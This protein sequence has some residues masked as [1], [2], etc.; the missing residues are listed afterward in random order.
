VNQIDGVL[1]PPDGPASWPASDSRKQWIVFYKADGMTLA[2]EGTIE[3]NGEEWWDLPCKP[4]RV[5]TTWLGRF[6][7]VTA[8]NYLDQT[9]VTTLVSMFRARTDQRCPGHATALQ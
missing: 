7:L 6:S 2:G 3:G 4:H 5:R 1:M 8:F 9:C